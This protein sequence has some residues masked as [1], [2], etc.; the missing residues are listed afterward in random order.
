MA[1]QFTKEDAWTGGDIDALMFFGPAT[2]DDALTVFNALWSFPQLSGPYR[3]R[4]VEPDAQSVITQPD[5]NDY[6]CEQLIGVYTHH[7]GTCSNL[8]HTTILDDDGLWV[9]AGPTTGSLPASWNIGAYPFE[10]GRPTTWL[11]PL[12]DDLR[13]ITQHVN[14]SK[15]MLGAMYGWLTTMDCDIL[16]DAIAGNIPTERWNPIDVWR[17]GQR[18]YYPPTHLESPMKI[19]K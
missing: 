5:C 18:Q 7:D 6:G 16:L 8:V 2:V 10:D 14:Q 17:D 12:Y 3:S 19:D 9:Y 13:L 4:K 11:Q 15:P 1:R